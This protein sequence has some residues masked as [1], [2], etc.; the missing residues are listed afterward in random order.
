ME[1]LIITLTIKG[2]GNIIGKDLDKTII[3]SLGMTI[4]NG[5]YEQSDG[6]NKYIKGLDMRERLY[7][8]GVK[9]VS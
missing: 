3:W 2:D 7:Q 4:K 5:V 1:K 9:S 6:I 8:V